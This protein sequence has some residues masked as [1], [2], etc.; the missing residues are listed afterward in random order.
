MFLCICAFSS[1]TMV[2]VGVCART[3][4]SRSLR[5]HD[6]AFAVRL[7]VTP[8]LLIPVVAGGDILYHGKHAIDERRAVLMYTRMRACVCVRVMKGT[9]REE[10]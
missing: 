10:K 3:K 2:H 1:T 8:R 6:V 5:D 9:Q 4:P 7:L